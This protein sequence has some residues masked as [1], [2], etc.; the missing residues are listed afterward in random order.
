V[1]AIEP[2]PGVWGVMITHK[3]LTEDRSMYWQLPVLSGEAS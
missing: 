1:V 2:H 3:G